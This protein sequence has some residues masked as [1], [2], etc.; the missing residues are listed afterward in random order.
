MR[1]NMKHCLCLLGL[2]RLE[3]EEK[4]ELSKRS[5]PGAQT[6]TIAAALTWNLEAAR[7]LEI[8]GAIQTLEII[9]TVTTKM[10]LTQVYNYLFQVKPC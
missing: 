1:T 8:L 2:K 5:Q 3:V 10:Q 9:K 7:M 4:T 6:E